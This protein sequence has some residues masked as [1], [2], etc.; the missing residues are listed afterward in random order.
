MTEIFDT[1]RKLSPAERQLVE[2]ALAQR[3]AYLA[4]DGLAVQ[5][6]EEPRLAYFQR[7]DPVMRRWKDALIAQQVAADAV[8]AERARR[9]NKS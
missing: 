5:G 2:A 3:A 6:L 4:M 7:T 1:P 8:I 9:E